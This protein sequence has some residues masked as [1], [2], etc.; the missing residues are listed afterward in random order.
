MS[1]DKTDVLSSRDKPDGMSVE[2]ELA[3]ALS[4]VMRWPNPNGTIAHA[5]V[6]PWLR[7]IAAHAIGRYALAPNR[8]GEQA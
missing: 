5:Y 7:D 4:S 2:D 3:W 8:T 6:P 1:T